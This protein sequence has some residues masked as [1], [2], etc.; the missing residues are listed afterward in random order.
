[1]SLRRLTAA[2]CAV[3]ASISMGMAQ[4]GTATIAGRVTDPS[5]AVIAGVNVTVVQTA[6]NFQFTAVT[7][8]EGLFRVQS[9]QPGAYRITLEAAGFKRV[10]RDNVDL[11]TG[12]TLPVDVA[13]EVGNVTEA[14]EVTAQ[15]QLLETETSAVGTVMEGQTLYKLPLYQRYINST[16]NLVPGMTTA[17]YAYGGDLGAYHLAGQR[18]GAISISEDGVP[19]NNPQGGQ[20]STIKPIQNAVEEVKVLTT[21]LPAEYGHSAGGVI[22]VVKKSGTNQL[23]GMASDFGRTRLMQHRLFFDRYRNSQPQPGNPNGLASWFM[24]PDANV[25]GP[26]VLPKLYNG[27]NRTFFFFGYQKLIEKK[28]AQVIQ[29]TPSQAMKGGDFSFGGVGNPIY[30]P[31]TTRQLADGTWT[32]DVFPNRQVPVERIDPVARKILQIDPWV[33]ANLPGTLTSNGPSGNLIYNE[34]SR[35]FFEDFSGRIDHQ[36]NSNF[37]IYGSYTYNHQSGFGRPTNIRIADFDATNGNLTPLTFQNYSAGNTWVVNPSTVNDARVGYYR[38]RNDRLVPSFGKNYAQLLGI[39]NVN[40]ALLP[41]FGTGDQFTAD[42]IYGLTVSG[43][44]RI[45][46]ETLSFR[47]DLSKIHGTHA[48]KM[49][50]E[51]VRFRSNSTVTN[52]PSGDFRF[53]G[54]TAGLQPDGNTVPNTG[55]TFAGFLL[56][57]VRQASFDAELTS[58]LPRSAIHSVY[59]QD[60]WKFSPTLTLNLGIR[61]SNESP[62]NTKYGL[63]SNFNPNGADD[64]TGMKGAIAHTASGLNRRDNNNFQPRIGMAWHPLKKWVFRGGFTVNTVDVKFPLQRDQF[65]EYSALAVQQRAPGDPRSL[66]QLSRGPDPIQFNIRPNDTSPFVGTNFGGRSVS[67]WDP[68]LRNP[69]VLNW[70]ISPQYEINSS[71]IVKLIYQGSAG[72]GLLERWQINTFPLDYGANDPALRA[73]AFAK[74]Q[75]YR[76]YPQFGDILMRSNFGHSTFHSGTAQL[77]K[78]YSKGLVLDTFYT[79]SKSID[80]QDDDNNGSASCGSDP[81]KC[82]IAPIQNRSLEKARAGYDRNHRFI[83]VATYELP[84]GKGR[85]FMNHGGVWNAIFGD[86][87]IAWIQTA[88]SGNPLTFTF[89]NSPY[90]YFPTFAGSRRPNVV[91]SPRIR[92]N[93]GDFG[94]DRF[95]LQNINPIIDINYFA[96][97]AEFTPGNSGRNIVTGTRL[98]WSQVSAQ[99]NFR[100]ME[101]FNLQFRWDF[102]NPFHNYNFGPPTNTVDFKNPRTFGKDLNNDQRTASLGGQALMNFT[103]QLRW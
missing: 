21:T 44:T 84:V 18:N 11:R 20:V 96:Y 42:S 95:N 100:I 85:R 94:G 5:G 97:P 81:S 59:F 47:D 32:R 72:I 33:T 27:R 49:G 80:S 71:W 3:A 60:D 86:Y 90:N 35:T 14:V 92:D 76:P 30:D 66:Y 89:A 4:I 6:T 58:W 25:G 88:E 99:K 24:M 37:K 98:L 54:M 46:G 79:F 74:S 70:N 63:M 19:G 36:F 10:V 38:G 15:T 75:N 61:Y 40:G 57:S 102:Q 87:E 23:H 62:F 16:L 43:P 7:N 53:D 77:E 28:A 56:G 51:L 67:W 39:P 12:D 69:Y 22:S 93:W 1:M 41:S 73:A 9:L 65:D 50:Y 13:L 48:F 17:G 31:L 64:I 2:A 29:Q 83:A 101:R 52:R 34:K 103:L 55:N 45:I 68:N 91:G 26:I 82:G 8:N 78:R